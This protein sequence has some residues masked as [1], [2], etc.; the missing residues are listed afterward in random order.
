MIGEDGSVASG[1]KTG[2]E[3]INLEARP[4][5]AN[6]ELSHS[7]IV[8]LRFAGRVYRQPNRAS[9]LF[10]HKL[11]HDVEQADATS[12][13]VNNGLGNLVLSLQ[14]VEAILRVEELLF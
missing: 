1:E 10:V 8:Y 12:V 3:E 13:V 2:A 5:A 4:C 9:R 14:G 11:H 6:V 7:L